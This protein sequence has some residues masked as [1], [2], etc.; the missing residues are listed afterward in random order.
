MFLAEDRIL[1][2]ELVMK[3]N[4]KWTLAYVKHSKADTD[5]PESTAEFISQRR[6]WINGSF[7]A[8]VVGRL[9]PL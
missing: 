8:S 6:R 9:T 7:A 2:F 1:C 4:E 3:A 5:V